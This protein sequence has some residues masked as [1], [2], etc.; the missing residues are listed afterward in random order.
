[1][2]NEVEED[3]CS[4]SVSEYPTAGVFDKDQQQPSFGIDTE[5]GNSNALFSASRKQPGSVSHRLET[6][7]D[8]M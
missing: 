3:E 4:S 2:P 7:Y 6:N 5:A 8:Q 1:M